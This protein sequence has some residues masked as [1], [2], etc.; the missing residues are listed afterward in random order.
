[1]KKLVA[2]F[3]ILAVFAG[4]IYEIREKVPTDSQPT[5]LISDDTG[6][7]PNSTPPSVTAAAGSPAAASNP[8]VSSEELTHLT[9]LVLD[10]KQSQESRRQAL[11]NLTQKG[12]PALAALSAVATASISE[13]LS[14][15]QQAFEAGL[16]VTAIES[17]DELA[18]D[19]SLSTT[20]KESMLNVLKMQKHQSLTLLAQISLSGIESGKPG[21]V[22]RAIDTLIKEQK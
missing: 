15:Y 4:V 11:Y 5:A 1:M 13:N 2:A 8:A 10:V 19:P 21:K 16:R 18:M 20:V 12:S 3:L 6:S 7:S 17:L 9:Q 22:K 14:E